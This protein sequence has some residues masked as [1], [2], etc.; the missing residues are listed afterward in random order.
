MNFIYLIVEKETY[1]IFVNQKFRYFVFIASPTFSVMDLHNLYL[2][3]FASIAVVKFILFF[4]KLIWLSQD[5]LTRQRKQ[6]EKIFISK[7][8]ITTS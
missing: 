8:A 3:I 6:L 2:F 7:S 4:K 5:K 1:F